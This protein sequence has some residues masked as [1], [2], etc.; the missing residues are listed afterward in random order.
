MAGL[1]GNSP[2][3]SLDRWKFAE[4][5]A[6]LFRYMGIGKEADVGDGKT[7]RRP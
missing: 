4:I 6:T 2:A 1:S 5:E 3:P 7:R